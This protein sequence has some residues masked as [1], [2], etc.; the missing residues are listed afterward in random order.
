MKK[1]KAQSNILATVLI[2]LISIIAV[3]IIYNVVLIL[4]KNSVAQINIGK[5]RTQLDI[6]DVNLWVTGGATIEVKRN[7]ILGGLD[8][9]KIVF[10]EENGINGGGYD[11]S[12]S[13]NG[14]LDFFPCR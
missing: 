9:L 5:L 1:G 8:S 3:I 10:Y 2:I 7:S 6:R 4:I 14:G 13:G 12:C 11:D